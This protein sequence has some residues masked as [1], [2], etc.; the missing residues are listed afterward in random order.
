MILDGGSVDI[1]VESTIVDM[2]VVPPMILRPG[3][4]TKEMLESCIGEVQVD[5]A[6]LDENSKE[7]P[8]LQE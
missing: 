5:R 4:V 6:I 2:T 7:A 8:K 1:G 3:A